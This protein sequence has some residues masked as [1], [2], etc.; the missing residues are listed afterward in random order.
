VFVPLLPASFFRE[1]LTILKLERFG[2]AE[3]LGMAIGMQI[4]GIA[5]SKIKVLA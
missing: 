5:G 4:V 1:N 3:Q 2:Q